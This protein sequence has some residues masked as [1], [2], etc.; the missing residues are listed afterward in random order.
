MDQSF[1]LSKSSSGFSLIELLVVMAIVGILTAIAV[2]QYN[3]YKKR[4]FDLRARIDLQNVATAEEAYFMDHERYL[5]C[6]AESCTELPGIKTLSKGVELEVEASESQFT[7][8]ASHPKGS[9]KVF[10]W[11]S[12]AGGF[13]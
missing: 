10:V 12:D 2:P 8:R 11:E 3:D 6:I 13:E 7:G 1:T 9:G 4:A 5:P